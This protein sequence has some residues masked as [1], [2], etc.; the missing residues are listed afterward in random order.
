MLPVISIG[1]E[2]HGE[3]QWCGVPKP[4][5]PY[6]ANSSEL[7]DERLSSKMASSST[8]LRLAGIPGALL[9]ETLVCERGK[10]PELTE[11]AQRSFQPIRLWFSGQALCTGSPAVV[12]QAL[13]EK[14]DVL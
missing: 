9:S 8:Y 6:V 10:I 1:I 11:R 5:E 4:G 12:R 3:C 14:G 7:S 13:A 2:D